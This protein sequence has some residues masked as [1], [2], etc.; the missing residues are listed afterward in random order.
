MSIDRSVLEAKGR[1][2]AGKGAARKLRVQGL[3]P[4]VI[5]GRALKAPLHISVEPAAIRKAINTPHKR[6]T[7]INVK[8]AGS[9][10]DQQVILKDFQL[11]PVTREILHAD[12]LAVAENEQVKVLV[13]LILVGRAQGVAD[14]GILS[15]A[16]RDL[17]VW[18]LPKAIPEKI[19]I[20]VTNLKI[21]EALH[22]NDVKLP[23]GVTVKTHVNFTIAVVSVPEREEAAIPAAAATPAAGA[24]PAG[25]AKAAPAAGGAAAAAKKDDK[26]K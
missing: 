10:G 23:E 8:V 25:D 2:A 14:G 16:R 18:A 3:V 22:I 6:N 17:E 4:A 21:A 11:D 12:F 26:K 19:E 13:P 15:Q 9:S 5:Y 1:E 20:D 24:A 7:L